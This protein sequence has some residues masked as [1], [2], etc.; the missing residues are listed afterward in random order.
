MQMSLA[1]GDVAELERLVV[2][3]LLGAR[4][5]VVGTR[6][7]WALRG[8][9]RKLLAPRALEADGQVL[10][11]PLCRVTGRAGHRHGRGGVARASVAASAGGLATLSSP[12]WPRRSQ[13]VALGDRY[14]VL[15]AA[16]AGGRV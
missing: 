8:G 6:R 9:G 4:L 14:V 15:T 3:V 1:A 5:G 16:A 13:R 10:C 2:V 7:R 12:L 11:T